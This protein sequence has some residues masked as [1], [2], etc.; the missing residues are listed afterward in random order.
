MDSSELNQVGDD[1][2]NWSLEFLEQISYYPTNGEYT[3]G[4]LVQVY[5]FNVLMKKKNDPND[6]ALQ[7]VEDNKRPF[8]L[9]VAHC[10][11]VLNSAS[12]FRPKA[13]NR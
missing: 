8:A 1:I 3:A 10:G 7:E 9:T 5:F 2:N 4:D 6:A 13:P 11:A 12:E